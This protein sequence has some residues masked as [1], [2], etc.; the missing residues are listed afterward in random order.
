VPNDKTLK[1]LE[2]RR[3][4]AQLSSKGKLDAL[5]SDE[6]A[7]ALIHS[8][9][10]EDLYFAI[11][12]VGLS[13]AVEVVQ[14]A[15]P[16][17]FRAF[18]DLGGW[19]KD[20]LQIASVLDWL[21]V[22]RGEDGD[23]FLA[24]LVGLDLEV[25][26]LVLRTHVV[27]HSLEEDPDVNPQRPTMET[28]EGKYLLELTAEGAD[29]PI[30]REIL[31][32]LIA[33]NPF[34][35]VR[36]LEAIRWEV[37]TELEEQAYQFRQARLGDL[38]FPPFEEASALFGRVPVPPSPQGAPALTTPGRVDFLDAALR[39]LTPEERDN[40]Q[41]E[42]RYLVNSALVAEGA[43]PG[44]VHAIRDV[45]ERARDYL[46][47][48]LEQLASSPDRA[49]DV[50]RETP[51]RRIF[52]VGFSLT[53]TLKHRAD[54]LAR[55]PFAR[56]GEAWLIAPQELPGFEALR[57]KRPL[58]A[59]KV[60]G[61]EPVPFRSR[62]ELLEADQLLD[63]VEAQIAIA[64]GLLGPGVKAG[65]ERLAGW[66]GEVD[67]E[68]LLLAA[69]AHALAHGAPDV[70][71]LTAEEARAFLDQ[72]V[73]GGEGKATVDPAALAK[74][75]GAIAAQVPAPLLSA[76]NAQVQRTLERLVA[77]LGPS[78]RAGGVPAPVLETLLPITP[79][80]P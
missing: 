8:V 41:D 60:E 29:F 23:A 38:G 50:V 24:K 39:G 27:I 18:V 65:Q 4:L 62:K 16:G 69:L 45:S 73:G 19:K 59:L 37:P 15:S 64:A 1:R 56:V 77:E 67:F 28:P 53:L 51:S 36:L 2:Q 78:H 58:R 48:G 32:D 55:L 63:R 31:T 13:D 33:K 54:R 76:A 47:L 25:L 5:L 12:D 40:L 44:D 57:R 11:V 68:R 43:E 75:Q 9:P 70:A 7:A 26:E 79:A 3:Q 72:V 74:A 30:V 14:L 10:A 34:E 61:A 20:G 71:P 17:Q 35:A 80:G 22:A 42:L 49:A 46:A 52:Q 6:D 66:P 21:R